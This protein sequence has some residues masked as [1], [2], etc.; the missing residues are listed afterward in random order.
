MGR[1]KLIVFSLIFNCSSSAFRYINFDE[2]QHFEG[3]LCQPDALYRVAFKIFDRNAT[4]VLSF[5]NLSQTAILDLFLRF[6]Q[7]M[8]NFFLVMV[9][10][11]IFLFLQKEENID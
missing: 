6:I 8:G 11:A 7:S 3:L 4:G 1:A 9:P 2:F 5:G 10:Y